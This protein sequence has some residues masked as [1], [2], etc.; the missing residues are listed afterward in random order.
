MMMMM[1]IFS[2]YW[3]KCKQIAFVYRF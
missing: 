3:R 1:M 2:R